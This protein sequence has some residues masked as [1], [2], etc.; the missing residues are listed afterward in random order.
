[1]QLALLQKGVPTNSEFIMFIILLLCFL[2][3]LL[4]IGFLFDWIK[5]KPWR[6]EPTS[7]E[8]MITENKTELNNSSHEESH[9]GKNYRIDG[10]MIL[11]HT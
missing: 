2:S 1:M 7:V 4:L 5:S 8:N 9:S 6:K 3:F 10:S 11:R